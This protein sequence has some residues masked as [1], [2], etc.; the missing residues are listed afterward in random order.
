MRAL[1]YPSTANFYRTGN[2]MLFR[3]CVVYPGNKRVT[4]NQINARSAEDAAQAAATSLSTEARIEV[5]SGADRVLVKTRSQL[6]RKRCL[7]LLAG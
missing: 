4:L 1:R 2:N 7:A 5:W 6:H 3:C